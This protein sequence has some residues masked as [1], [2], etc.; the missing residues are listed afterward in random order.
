MQAAASATSIEP[1]GLYLEAGD[2]TKDELLQKL[3]SGLYITTLKGLHAGADVNSGDFSL[4][5]EGF[6]V[7]NGKKTAPVKNFTVADNFFSLL[8][9]VVALS[10]EVDF[11][12]A[13]QIGAPDVMISDVSI[14]G[15]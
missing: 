5:A 15:K 6:L 1:K 8:K 12:A 2:L 9:R 3:G 14:S 11:G 4:E 13:G 10:N 7:E